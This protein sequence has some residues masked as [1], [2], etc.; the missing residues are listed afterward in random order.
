M[1]VGDLVEHFVDGA[2]GVI[3]KVQEYAHKD[4]YDVHFP[5]L[6]YWME[7]DSDWFTSNAI[8]VVNTSLLSSN[9]SYSSYVGN[10]P[11][12]KEDT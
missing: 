12:S 2:Y 7:G 4:V 1:K 9:R 8:K 10:E 6:V 3:I 11:R 5:Y